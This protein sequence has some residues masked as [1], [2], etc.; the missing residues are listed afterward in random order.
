MIQLLLD[1]ITVTIGV[2]FC[3]E[4]GELPEAYWADAEAWYGSYFAEVHGTG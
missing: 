2:S 3:D 1:G 4:A